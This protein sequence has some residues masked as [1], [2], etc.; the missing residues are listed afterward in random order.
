MLSDKTRI[1]ASWPAAAV[2]LAFIL[3]A[4]PCRGEDAV[5]SEP[6]LDSWAYIN[7]F[8]G[9]DR[10]LAPSYSGVA[11]DSQTEQFF[12]NDHQS[13]ARLGSMLMAFETS[14]QITPGL[15]PSRYQVQSATVTVRLWNGSTGSLSYS[16]QPVTPDSLLAEALGGGISVQKP[17]EL[18]GVGFRD[19]YEGFDLGS[20]DPGV[21]FSEGTSVY[22]ASDGGYVAF[23]IVGDGQDAYADVS[24]NLA[25]GFSETAPGHLTAPFDATP[26]AIGDAGLSDGV[27]VPDDTA[28]TFIVDLTEPGVVEYL[29]QSL[30]N[31]AV[32]FFL[33]SMHPAAQPGT[34]GGGAY[35]QWYTKEAA[36]VFAGAEAP[37]LSIEYAILDDFAAGDYDRNG[38]VDQ[39]D[40]L[41]WRA[42]YGD[43]VSTPGDGADGNG[44][45]LV[46][47]ADYSIWRDKLPLA[48]PV[49]AAVPE[50][51]AWLLA[52]L[53]LTGHSRLRDLRHARI[54]ELP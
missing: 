18:Y 8:G 14:G 21:Y 24:N 29:Q 52:L 10:L 19:G 12:L 3:S 49:A 32:G 51:A 41:T 48:S 33:S 13:P 45:G 47:T 46:D 26:W 44:D 25:G 15:E 30:A 36:G 7:G 20:P 37:S 38:V 11:V 4:A 34:S 27:S 50:P 54:G 23:P 39:D 6:A 2:L 22:S 40:Y 35:P 28:F 16:T 42:A 1:S 17:M 43:S 31:G 5:W 53:A 9:G